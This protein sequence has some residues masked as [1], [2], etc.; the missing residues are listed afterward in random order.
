MPMRI[1]VALDAHGA[2]DGALDEALALAAHGSARLRLLHVVDHRR[3]AADRTRPTEA[4]GE[5]SV[6]PL[7]RAA[8]FVRSAG[9]APE[10]RVVSADDRTVADAILAEARRWPADLLALG[11]HGDGDPVRAPPGSVTGRVV[12]GEPVPVLL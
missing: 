8:R 6:D 4:A 11:T 7:R 3:P 1:L 2:A 9:L 12:R 10:A 5:A